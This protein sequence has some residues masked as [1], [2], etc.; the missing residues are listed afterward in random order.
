[1]EIK[2]DTDKLKQIKLFI[3]T[4]MYGGMAHGLYVKSSLDL[5]NVTVEMYN[6]YIATTT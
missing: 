1:M 5:Q 3:A 6:I 4:P 2:L